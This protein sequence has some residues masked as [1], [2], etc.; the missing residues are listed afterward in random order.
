[1]LQPAALLSRHLPTSEDGLLTPAH[2][3]QVCMEVQPGTHSHRHARGMTSPWP[4]C[5]VS[6]RSTPLV[7]HRLQPTIKPP[8]YPLKEEAVKGGLQSLNP[9]A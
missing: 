7:Q 2:A 8:T 5:K 9:G 3:S 6:H 1:M 4:G